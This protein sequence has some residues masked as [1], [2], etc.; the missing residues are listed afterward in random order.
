MM[1]IFDPGCITVVT[2]KPR[3]GKTSLTLL[4]AEM[5]LKKNPEIQI[6]SNIMIDKKL[7]RYHHFSTSSEFIWYLSQVKRG[8]FITDEAGTFATSGANDIKQVR[9]QLEAFA[10][11]AGHFG[12]STIWIDQRYDNSV[13]PLIRTLASYRFHCPSRGYVEM[14]EIENE[15]CNLIQ[16]WE[17]DILPSIQYDSKGMANFDW[18]L[19][20]DISFNNLFNALSNTPS[21]HF[22]EKII[23]WCNRNGLAPPRKDI[24]KGLYSRESTIEGKK[25]KNDVAGSWEKLDPFTDKIPEKVLIWGIHQ[26]YEGMKNPSISRISKFLHISETTISKY[27]AEYLKAKKSRPN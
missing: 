19:P 21:K 16:E 6:I 2:G 5:A 13:P 20:K 10:K 7:D 27:R 24:F 25:E 12:L 22:P 11:L 18:D 14:Y 1:S 9:G 15:Q 26:R 23:E 4:L 8:I 3:C 17:N